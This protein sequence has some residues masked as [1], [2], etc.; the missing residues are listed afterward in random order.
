[1]REHLSW[2]IRPGFGI[3]PRLTALAFWLSIL[4]PSIINVGGIV[5]NIL[6]AQFV[7]SVENGRECGLPFWYLLGRNSSSDFIAFFPGTVNRGLFS[8]I[9]ILIGGVLFS[10]ISYLAITGS[11]VRHAVSN[12]SLVTFNVVLLICA[13]IVLIL[14][15]GFGLAI[16][17][18]FNNIDPNSFDLK[19]PG[20]CSW[21]DGFPAR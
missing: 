15:F 10:Y 11:P 9:T 16:V 2:Y 12:W 6:V 20:V 14:Q 17:V 7:K 4:I 1:M 19:L 8:T 5:A 3:V 18:V 13:A 21:T